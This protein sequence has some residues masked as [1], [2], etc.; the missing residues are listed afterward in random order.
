MVILSDR[1]F[2]EFLARTLPLLG[3]RREG[4][5]K[6]RGQVRKRVSRRIR[7]LGLPGLEAYRER[8]AEDSGE[9]EVLDGLCRITISRFYREGHVFQRLAESLPRDAK[10]RVW[11][12]GCA[13]GEE[14]Y[15]LVLLNRLSRPDLDLR[16]LATDA[17]P[18]LL[19]RARRAR[20]PGSSLR[21]LPP[22]WIARAF[23]PVGDEQ[24][25]RPE[26]RV[27]IEWRREDLR[28]TMPE[29][30]FDLV[31][32]RYLVLTYFAAEVQERVLD[33]I[34]ARLSPDGLLVIGSKESPPPTGTPVAPGIL[35]F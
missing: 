15:S 17:D 2:R 18:H 4:F 7:A 6:V 8:V 30:P 13:S 24:E 3:L 32:C 10:L 26:Y 14:P 34:R 33:G 35:R 1:E 19:E 5:R 9:R 31:L 22:G 16:I 23:I 28:E 20:Y 12:A 25:L 21:E 29:G 27:G 11:C